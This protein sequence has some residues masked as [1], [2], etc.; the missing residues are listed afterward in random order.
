[1]KYS[2]ASISSLP[3]STFG[4]CD[5]RRVVDTR[6]LGQFFEVFSDPRMG[7]LISSLRA[8]PYKSDEYNE[9]KRHIPCAT[10]SCVCDGIRG[11]EHVTHR[12]PIICLD[13]DLGDNPRLAEPGFKDR[14]ASALLRW[15][16]TYAVGTSC[17]G[18]G[19]FCIV[20]IE[21]NESQEAFEEYF[22]ALES[23]FSSSGIVIDKSCKDVTRLRIASSDKVYIKDGLVTAY[24]KRLK[25][26]EPQRIQKSFV[27]SASGLDSKREILME[28][29]DMIVD[30]GVRADSYSEWLKMAF[31]LYPLGSDGLR[32]LDE[33]SSR[34]DGYK[35]FADVSKKF[36]EVS[37][38]RYT[39]D[40]ACAYFF[41]IAKQMFGPG[42]IYDAKTR[43]L[44]RKLHKI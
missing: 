35:G 14:L 17:S 5:T 40:D 2:A 10:I 26:P 34:S 38:S 16:S 6:T 27:N 13:V 23:D 28:V 25:A 30:G 22:R 32:V 9:K 8:L 24:S 20:A 33:I 7:A 41:S 29:L 36:S 3:V 11:G 37:N 4:S 21:S 43:I 1:M 18:R 12:N 42:Y 39:V 15:E 44:K 19:L 31:F